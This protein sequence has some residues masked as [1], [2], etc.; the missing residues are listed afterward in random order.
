MAFHL[1]DLVDLVPSV[2]EFAWFLMGF[3]V[4]VVVA[5]LILFLLRPRSCPHCPDRH[6]PW[7]QK[8]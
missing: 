3:G 6:L 4:G 1:V 7:L 2:T 8:R 5:V